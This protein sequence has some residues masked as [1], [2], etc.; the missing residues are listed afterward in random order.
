MLA[1]SLVLGVCVVLAAV[2]VSRQGFSR[3]KP[4]PAPVVVAEFDTVQI[5]VPVEPVVVGT[6]VKD[7][8]FKTVTFPKHQVPLGSITTLADVSEAVVVA[9]LPAN[10]PLFR[11]NLSFNAT[12]TNPVTERIPPGMRAMTVRVDATAAV[13]GWAGSGSVVDVL[14][15]E[16]DRT[17]VVAE[18][19]KILSAER[20]VTPV[21]GQGTPNVPS[22]VTLLVTQEQ[23]LGI[24]TA[25]PRGRIAFALRSTSDQ[26]QWRD[27]V[28]NASQLSGP[29]DS[30]SEA[31]QAVEG[32][33]TLDG[34]NFAVMKGRLVPVD[35]TIPGRLP[36][37]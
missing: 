10:V 28:F 8:K 11:P 32:Y 35:G 15:V 2:L 20:S 36:P 9:S 30:G 31:R 19:V 27:P 13:E 23:C 6:R 22:T 7:I 5:P 29:K 37:P 25:I 33:L 24:N 16:R 1:S 14:L 21:E 18:N 34:K 26:D 3:E 4:A 17:T 12:G